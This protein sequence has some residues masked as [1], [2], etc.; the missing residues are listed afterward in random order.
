MLSILLVLALTGPTIDTPQPETISDCA[1]M[2][3]ILVEAD[4]GWYYQWD[5]PG[6]LAEW[7]LMCPPL[8][9]PF[10]TIEDKLHALGI[11]Q[12]ESGLDPMA[13]DR[14]WGHLRGSRPQGNYSIVSGSN[15]P[16]RLGVPYLDPYEP[17]QAA[18]LAAILVYDEINPKVSAPN[19][20][21]WWSCSH[22]M[23]T[24]Y[25]R[26]GIHAPEQWYCPARNYWQKVPQG[27]GLAAKRDCGI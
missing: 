2:Y 3:Q 11:A 13:N 27:S 12:C 9:W 15:W 5:E 6:Q 4:L 1:W 14:R 25:A 24:Y 7:R 16:T 8:T 18:L 20:Y 22:Y 19:F 21:W 23:H 17:L 10:R 26:L